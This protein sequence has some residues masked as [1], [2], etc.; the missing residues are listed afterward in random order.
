MREKIILAE[1]PYQWSN[2]Y[3]WYVGDDRKEYLFSIPFDR[4]IYQ[5]FRNGLRLEELK[6]HHVWNRNKVMDHLIEKR[7]PYE[8]KRL[9]KRREEEMDGKI[10]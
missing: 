5:Y 8:M 3:F 10:K 7:I 2:I 9:K 1:Q 4:E 6:K